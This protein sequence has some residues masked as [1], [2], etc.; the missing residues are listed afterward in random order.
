MSSFKTLLKE[1]YPD[2]E[3]YEKVDLYLIALD[4]ALSGLMVE[5]NIK[6]PVSKQIYTKLY[7]EVLSDYMTGN[8]PR[9]W[10]DRVNQL[11]ND[12][13]TILTELV[14]DFYYPN[15]EMNDM[16]DFRNII[17]K[18]GEVLFNEYYSQIR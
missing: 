9:E 13:L 6:Q 8:A 3:R 1:K 5:N 10:S 4:D 15:L 7:S 14:K 2:K 16:D 17:Q 18:S 12:I 11:M